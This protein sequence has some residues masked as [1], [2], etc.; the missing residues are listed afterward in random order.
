MKVSS[1]YVRCSYGH[2]DSIAKFS[3]KKAEAVG[4]E[5]LKFV[6]AGPDKITRSEITEAQVTVFDRASRS[7]GMKRDG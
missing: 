1:Y 5:N 4:W 3:A 6:F 7:A 2:V